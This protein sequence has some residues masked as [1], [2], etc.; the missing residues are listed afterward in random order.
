MMEYEKMKILGEGFNYYIPFMF[1]CVFSGSLILGTVLCFILVHFEGKLLKNQEEKKE[2]QRAAKDLRK[3]KSK[4][5]KFG[6]FVS[7]FKEASCSLV[8]SLF[9]KFFSILI[10]QNLPLVC[11]FLFVFFVRFS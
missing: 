6:H 2:E 4:K 8:L 1:S 9:P 5:S 11:T 7:F 3:E 10:L